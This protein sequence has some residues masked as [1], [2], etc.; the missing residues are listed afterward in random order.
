MR[1]LLNTVAKVMPY[2]GAAA[3]G[4]LLPDLALAAGGDPITDAGNN[5]LDIGIGL[6]PIACAA[7]VIGTCAGGLMRSNGIMAGGAVTAVCGGAWTGAPQLVQK[8]SGAAAGF[9][10]NDLISSAGPQAV[11]LHQLLSSI[12]G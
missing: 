4:I 11:S 1:K 5:A 8:V 3:V 10:L 12:L 2:V 6:G 9:S 7:G